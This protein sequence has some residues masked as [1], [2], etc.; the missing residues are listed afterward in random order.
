[1]LQPCVKENGGG[2]GVSVLQRDVGQSG[3]RENSEKYRKRQIRITVWTVG[4][5][6]L[7]KPAG[8]QVSRSGIE[9]RTWNVS[10][11]FPSPLAQSDRLAVASFSE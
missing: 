6:R 10:V 1:M 9:C 7:L 5:L 2:R 3:A 8:Q 11:Y 4:R